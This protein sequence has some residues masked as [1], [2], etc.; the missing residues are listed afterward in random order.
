MGYP[1][2]VALFP[3]TISDNER[4]A[5]QYVT[6]LR[7]MRQ[8]AAVKAK[9]RSGMEGAVSSCKVEARKTRCKR[10]PTIRMNSARKS[11]PRIDSAGA[12]IKKL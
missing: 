4:E 2:L 6:N 3:I 10:G 1:V 9:R 8:M 5:G 11:W 12:V 7:A